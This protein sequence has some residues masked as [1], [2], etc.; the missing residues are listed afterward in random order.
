[1]AGMVEIVY[2][3]YG[4]Q[5]QGKPM[6]TVITALTGMAGE[7]IQALKPLVQQYVEFLLPPMVLIIA[8]VWMVKKI[9]SKR[10][11][12]RWLWRVL[13][14]V[15]GVAYCYVLAITKPEALPLGGKTTFQQVII[16]LAIGTA[17]GAVN[18]LLYD[19]FKWWRHR[20]E[21]KV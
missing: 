13:P 3:E 1:M 8:L 19:G 9:V 16:L 14:V 11:A 20:K 21:K 12:P 17:I 7:I 6:E 5:P 10:K 2:T 4:N 18:I 15:F